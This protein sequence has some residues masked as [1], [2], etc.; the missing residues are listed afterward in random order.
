MS[1]CVYLLTDG[2]VKAEFLLDAV[3]V[4]VLPQTAIPDESDIRKRQ[5][6]K[7]G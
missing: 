4:A 5:E 7:T 6:G 1:D 3:P 2:L